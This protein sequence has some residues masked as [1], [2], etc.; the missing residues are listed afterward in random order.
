LGI[1]NRRKEL[2]NSIEGQ[3]RNEKKKTK[4]EKWAT[5]TG[6]LKT[7]PGNPGLSNRSSRK[8]S[9]NTEGRKSAQRQGNPEKER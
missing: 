7:S 2:K 6:S 1:K 9:V 8:R 5:R 3:Q 4:H